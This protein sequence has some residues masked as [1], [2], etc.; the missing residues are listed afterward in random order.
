[1]PDSES[2]PP[3]ILKETLRSCLAEF[4]KLGEGL[5]KGD[6][7]PEDLYLRRD[8]IVKSAREVAALTLLTPRK[9]CG[10][11]CRTQEAQ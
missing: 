8:Q 5:A 1:M 7:K 10:P 3:D 9:S 2:V 4:Q 11:D 6:L